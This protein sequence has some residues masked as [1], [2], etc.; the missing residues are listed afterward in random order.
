MVKN[1]SS[2]SGS[3]VP[4]LVY[5]DVG[6]AIIWLCETFGFTERFRYGSENRPSGAQLAV[7]EGSVFLIAPR[8]SEWADRTAFQPP[9]KTEV[10]HAIHVHVENVD[11]HYERVKDYG[12]QILNP[13]ET[14]AFGERQY[15]VKDIGGH[16][17]TFTESVADVAPE[18]WGGFSPSPN[19]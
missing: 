19:K 11:A 5:E 7:G 4:S 18:E 2:A 1:R 8:V 6:G 13:P 10:S 3:I 14:Y 12:A 9:R 15:T 16:R 17:W